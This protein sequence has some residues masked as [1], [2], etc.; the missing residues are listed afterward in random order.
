MFD[1]K[2]WITP[3]VVSNPIYAL[4]AIIAVV[5]VGA[6]HAFTGG[7]FITAM[8]A[9]TIGSMAYHAGVPKANN[10]DVMG[11]FAVG[12]GLWIYTLF[13]PANAVIGLPD[14]VWE[15]LLALGMLVGGGAAA[16]ALRMKQLDVPMEV[17]VGALFAVLY[18]TAFMFNGFNSSLLT[19][20]GIMIV[21]LLL[22]NRFHWL[23]HLISGPAL[24]LIFVGVTPVCPP[25]LM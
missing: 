23:W 11:I 2:R 15:P 5:V 7:A 13:G 17:K 25:T 20:M 3:D 8:T 24:A 1:Y 4:S 12:V 6:G 19:S 18:A 10:W 21:A 9:L 16:F 22:R 14:G